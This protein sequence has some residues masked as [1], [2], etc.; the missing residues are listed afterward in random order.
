MDTAD[1]IAHCAMMIDQAR[2][3]L[4]RG[5]VDH[6]RDRAN[7]A[8]EHARSAQN[9]TDLCHA[10]QVQECCEAAEALLTRIAERTAASQ[11][12]SRESSGTNPSRKDG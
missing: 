9:R 12:P 8:R 7:A 5:D 3:L 1:E 11:R 2:D 10:R 6:A 4:E